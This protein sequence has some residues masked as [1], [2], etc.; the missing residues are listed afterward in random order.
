MEQL[1]L[2]AECVPFLLRALKG[3]TTIKQL[4]LSGN[5]LMEEGLLALITGDKSA[6]KR[7]PNLDSI[8]VSSNMIGPDAKLATALKDFLLGNKFLKSFLF[9]DNPIDKECGEILLEAVTPKEK[10]LEEFSVFAGL[11]AELYEKL[12]L[13]KGGGKKKKGK[14]KK[15]KK[16]K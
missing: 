3:N 10:V 13:S 1:A 15:K 5:N 7:V 9:H 6:L 2:T 12:C 11:P 4:S 8:D 16:K 14:K